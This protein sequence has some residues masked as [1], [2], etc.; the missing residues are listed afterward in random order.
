[1]VG[2]VWEYPSENDEHRYFRRG[3]ILTLP[4]HHRL[5][6]R[7]CPESGGHEIVGTAFPE[8]LPLHV[9]LDFLS[10]GH[11]AVARV[12]GQ[13]VGQEIVVSLSPSHLVGG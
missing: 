4:S 9:I 6:T 1:M 3:E 10:L 13:D 7:E 8:G 12:C 11:L 5:K 2:A